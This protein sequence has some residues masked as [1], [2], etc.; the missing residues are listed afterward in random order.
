MVKE[1][2]LYKLKHL[3]QKGEEKNKINRKTCVAG[4]THSDF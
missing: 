4:V 3:R 1:T 2:K